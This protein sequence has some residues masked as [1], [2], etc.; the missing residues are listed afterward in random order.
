MFMLTVGNTPLIKIEGIYTKLECTN[1]LGSVK[2]RIAKYIIKK[3]ERQELLKKGQ[4][5]V[6][7]TSGNTGIALAYY[8][9]LAG[10]PVTIVMP[11]DMTEERKCRIK[12]FG[13]EL[14][15]CAEGNFAEAKEIRD[16]LA[17]EK[18][19]FNINQ[20]ANPLNTDC[21]YRNTGQEIIRQIP[22]IADAFVAGVGTGG[23]LIGVG[24]ALREINLSTYIAAV[25]PLESAVMSGGKPGKHQIQ[26]I[27]D[28][29]IP[30][31]VRGPR[32]GLHELIDEVLCIS[33]QEALAAAHYIE[34]EHHFCVG[35]SSGANFL[36]AKKLAERFK[37]VVTIFPD[38]YDRYSSVGLKH[39]AEGTCPYEIERLT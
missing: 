36:A 7:A 1:P 30:E 18:G 25:E 19:Y 16:K 21:H 9:R 37:T 15:L 11:C 12:E 3:S 29:F 35:A 4:P 20:F 28:G 31:I 34:K 33:G 39:C 38:S 32:T 5:V 10:H 26:G 14:I 24:Q 8:G 6:E 17:A 2:D 23:T 22:V 13:A 27:G